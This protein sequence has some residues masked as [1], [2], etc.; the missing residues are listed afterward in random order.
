MTLFTFTKLVCLSP[1]ERYKLGKIFR[2]ALYLKLNIRRE[3]VTTLNKKV[4]ENGSMRYL[5]RIYTPNGS[6]SYLCL[7]HKTLTVV[8]LGL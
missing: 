2:I 7:Y 5:N 6:K 3:V 1:I 4:E 8:V